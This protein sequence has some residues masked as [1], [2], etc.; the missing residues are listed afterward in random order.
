MK[1]AYASIVTAVILSTALS[2]AMAEKWSAVGLL[3]TQVK[4]QS[5]KVEFLE[6]DDFESRDSCMNMVMSEAMSKEYIGQGG[7]NGRLPEVQWNYDADCWLK[8]SD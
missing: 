8:R 4:G 2:T 3:T 6:I 1:K 5:A 7:T